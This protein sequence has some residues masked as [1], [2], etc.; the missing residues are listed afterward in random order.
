MLGVVCL[1]AAFPVVLM[2]RALFLHCMVLA[3]PDQHA[4]P[5]SWIDP[6]VLALIGAGA[7]MSGT[8]RLVV[9]FAA[10][11]VEISEYHVA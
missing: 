3:G 6:G 7:F 5:W 9:A 1:P 11:C 2:T 10:I 4:T 8:T